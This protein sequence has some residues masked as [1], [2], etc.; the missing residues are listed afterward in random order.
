M[1]S[2]I[3]NNPT[4]MQQALYLTQECIQ[5]IDPIPNADSHPLYIDSSQ[6]N[7]SQIPT[8]RDSIWK[9]YNPNSWKKQSPIIIFKSEFIPDDLVT[10]LIT[11]KRALA[12][13]KK[14][15]SGTHIT[16]KEGFCRTFVVICTSI[17]MSADYHYNQGHTIAP[18]SSNYY[19][20]NVVLFSTV[21]PD[22]E[23]LDVAAECVFLE[24]NPFKG[25]HKLN[26]TP[27][28]NTKDQKDVQIHD[29]QIK[30]WIIYYLFKRHIKPS[31]Q[32]VSKNNLTS[33]PIALITS[34]ITKNQPPDLLIDKFMKIDA[35][36]PI[37]SL[38]FYGRARYKQVSFHAFLEPLYRICYLQLLNE[39]NAANKC[40]LNPYIFPLDPAKIFNQML[41]EQGAQMMIR[42][43]I[44]ALQQLKQSHPHL[45]KKMFAISFSGTSIDPRAL[46]IFNSVFK[47]HKV[48]MYRRESFFEGK[49]STYSGPQGVALIVKNLDNA[50]G[51]DNLNGKVYNGKGES[52][53]A[54]VGA[55]SNSS[56]LLS[57]KNP[58]LT[59][60]IMSV[61]TNHNPFSLNHFMKKV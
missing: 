30:Q 20:R 52:K 2:S 1:A 29:H 4:S 16:N 14:F 25:I 36:I 19:F 5:K 54:I 17:K 49:N 32:D 26:W 21:H 60:H 10:H 7:S 13:G 34:L 27:L 15:I 39:L 41:G 38:S 35:K 46:I 40:I 11:K 48:T 57:P 59:D 55:Y 42:L 31:N 43:Q 61:T 24:P 3:S 53:D 50:F 51:N 33:D 28:K 44:L 56:L 6:L 18:F 23:T 47:D 37:N 12:L 9:N 8:N 58:H 45:F 22:F